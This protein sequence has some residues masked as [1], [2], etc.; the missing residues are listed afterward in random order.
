MT[1]TGRP[2]ATHFFLS[3]AHTAPLAGPEQEA[4]DSWVEKLFRDLSAAVCRTAALPSDAP[5]GFFDGKL[6]AGADWKAETT[7]QLSSAEVFVPLYSS[8]YF[9]MSWP[10]REWACFATRLSDEPLD[11]PSPHIVP[12]LWAPLPSAPDLP[13][14]ANPLALAADIPEYAENGLRALNM[15]RLYRELYDEIVVRIAERITQVARNLRIGPRAVPPLDQMR[16]AFRR[17]G[18]DDD[19]VFAVA[20]PTA[21]TV[22]ADRG[23]GWYGSESTAWRPFGDR[24]QLSLA[25]HAVALAERLGFSTEARPV[26]SAADLDVTSPTVVLIDP[27]I[28]A[29]LDRPESREL[30]DLRRLFQGDRAAWTLPLV[31]INGADPE[32]DS[33]HGRLSARIAS[34]LGEAGALATETARQ[35]AAGVTSLE[36]FA[37]MM[38]TLV[39]EAERNYL[40]RSPRFAQ[41]AAAD[42]VTR[43]G[44]EAGE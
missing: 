8:R 39:A 44:F 41:D 42:R 28:A 2:L 7:A 27:W 1:E 20:A 23:A 37:R 25:D 10:G 31:V 15:L 36:E 13:E 22:P 19:F 3:Y 34:I 12:V 38:P 26:G 18:A 43:P 21:G 40:R 5:V 33:C 4:A 17:K 32:S 29:P 24:Q 11:R 9:A 35:G 16:S 14:A 6:P 30:G